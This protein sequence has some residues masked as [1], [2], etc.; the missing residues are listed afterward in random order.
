MRLN[1]FAFTFLVLKYLVQSYNRVYILAYNLFF[2]WPDLC[3]V[4][5]YSEIY[6]TLRLF[7]YFYLFS[8]W[9]RRKHVVSSFLKDKICPGRLFHFKRRVFLPMFDSPLHLLQK[10]PRTTKIEL[11]GNLVS[12]T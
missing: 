1:L 8:G 12:V 3:F 5:K 7:S 6:P 9:V 10:N 11:N 4:M 2:E